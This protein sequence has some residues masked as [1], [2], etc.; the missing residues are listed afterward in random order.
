MAFTHAYFLS[1]CSPTLW[2]FLLVFCFCLFVH[3]FVSTAR[4][5]NCNF[6]IIRLDVS[7]VATNIFNENYPLLL[8]K[9][10]TTTRG[11][12]SDSFFLFFYFKTVRWN[13]T[14]EDF[15]YVAQHNREGITIKDS[16]ILHFQEK[17]SMPL[18]ICLFNLPNKA[19]S[20]WPL[21][22]FELIGKVIFIHGRTTF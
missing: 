12:N 14:I 18:K 16:A 4:I 15:L 17:L 1:K 3:L 10:P 22:N 11:Y 9:V 19:S 20:K 21:S 5:S 8:N 7:Y 13:P 6:E 2:K